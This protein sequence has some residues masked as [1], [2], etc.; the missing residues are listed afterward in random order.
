MP[1]KDDS[2]QSVAAPAA[3]AA[4]KPEPKKAPKGKQLP[5][6]WEAIE[7]ITKTQRKYFARQ[8]E[9]LCGVEEAAGL[10]LFLH[11]RNTGADFAGALSFVV[12]LFLFECS[13][14]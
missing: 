14:L 11:N 12:W 9:T 1:Q 6:G 10:P 2:N 5:P 7:R 3:V 4:V 13:A 8:L